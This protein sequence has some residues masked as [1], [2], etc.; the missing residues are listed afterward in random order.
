MDCRGVLSISAL[1][2]FASCADP[3]PDPEHLISTHRSQP[4]D[5]RAQH[6]RGKAGTFREGAAAHRPL[7]GSSLGDRFA[8]AEPVN[9]RAGPGV[10]PAA[11]MPG[12][13]R[14]C[15]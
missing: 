5:L 2:A 15:R 12:I 9:E 8:C 3:S 4:A 7:A 10:A 13:V 1:V 14:P 11:P 6:L